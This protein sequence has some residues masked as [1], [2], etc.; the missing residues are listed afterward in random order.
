M[1]PVLM[2]LFYCLFQCCKGQ[3]LPTPPDQDVET[4]V[5]SFQHAPGQY[6]DTF[7]TPDQDVETFVDSTQY[8]PGQYVDTFY[9]PDQDVE[10][11]AD[12]TQYAPGQY[13]DTFYTPD[14]DLPASPYVQNFYTPDQDDE[15]FVDSFQYSLGQYGDT[16]YTPDQDLPASPH[17][18]KSNTL[19]QQVGDFVEA[20]LIY[21]LEQ[22]HLTNLLHANED[23]MLSM[24]AQKKILE[25][26]SDWDILDRGGYEPSYWDMIR[27]SFIFSVPGQ[28]NTLQYSAMCYKNE[29]L[30]TARRDVLKNLRAMCI[31]LDCIPDD[32][33]MTFLRWVEVDEPVTGY[34]ILCYDTD[35][36]DT[37]KT[38][39][40]E[41]MDVYPPTESQTSI[42]T[43][44]LCIVTSG[45]FT[46]PPS[47]RKC[48]LSLAQ[49]ALM[50][51]E[52]QCGITE[53][54]KWHVQ[55]VHEEDERCT[56]DERTY[57]QRVLWGLAK[58]N[59][60]I[61]GCDII[62]VVVLLLRWQLKKGHK[63]SR[64]FV[65][66]FVVLN[67]VCVAW[68]LQE[69]FNW[70]NNWRSDSPYMCIVTY[71][72][73]YGA[74]AG[75]LYMFAC[76]SLHRLQSVARPLQWHARSMPRLLEAAIILLGVLVG[77]VISTLNLAAFWYMEDDEILKFCH[78]TRDAANMPLYFL[79]VVKALNLSLVFVLPF[80]VIVIAN[81]AMFIAH[82]QF[83]KKMAEKK[84][85]RP[86]KKKLTFS[87][88]FLFLS[89]LIITSCLVTP[90][91]ELKVSLETHQSGRMAEQPKLDIIGEG[92]L[93]NV[94][95]FAFM[96]VAL[97]GMKHSP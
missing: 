82:R 27:V 89:C 85:R 46:R 77:I 64:R 51:F 44:I 54:V 55:Q 48:D 92:V 40:T 71:Y 65:L 33:S 88:M 80:I 68:R 96:L 53:H 29:L 18:E 45:S 97:T 59:Y 50:N 61:M 76:T 30:K 20:T 36:D 43:R 49:T 42:P 52:L 81:T 95:T 60:G 9:T 8:A 28:E 32:Q 37:Y 15:T 11:F 84:R 62:V 26:G 91:T 86:P 63:T 6:G 79:L 35:E 10:T 41:G 72:V 4:H 13:G 78:F 21:V 94:T 17:V 24:K 7:Y 31:I 93:W 1:G 47:V 90:A 57:A 39:T 38:G 66:A 2:V 58:T 12:S 23:A 74:E 73:R 19:D 16:F 87:W 25:S 22:V 67:F 14:Q 5:D 70:D 3:Y 69:T 56:M 34:D 75:M 83:R